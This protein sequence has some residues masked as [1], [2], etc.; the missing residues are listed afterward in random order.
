ME[1]GED[2][3]RRVAS[4]ENI[5]KWVIAEVLPRAFGVLFQGVIEE[6][7]EVGWSRGWI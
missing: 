1:Y 6:S 4:I 5:G 7:L 2:R 3:I